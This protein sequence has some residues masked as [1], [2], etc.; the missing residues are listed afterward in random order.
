[1]ATLV[2][3]LGATPAVAQWEAEADPLAYVVSGFSAHVARRVSGGVVRVQLG[4]FGADVP[5][6]LHGEPD[7][8]LRTRGV[9]FKADYFFAGKAIGA[10]VGVDADYS[11]LRYRLVETREAAERNLTGFGPRVGYRFEPGERLYVTPWV[12]L[13]Y[14][15]NSEDVVISERRVSQNNYAVFP[16]VHVGWRF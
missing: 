11:R 14:L 2:A 13:R 16:T 8:D 15:F 12:S 10:F 9:T 6:W 7:F 1:M 3:G 5:E 4:V